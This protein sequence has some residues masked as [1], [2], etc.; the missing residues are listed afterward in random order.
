MT[1]Q[2]IGKLLAVLR[3]SFPPRADVDPDALVAAFEIGLRGIS[4][5]AATIAVEEW[6]QSGR[7]FPAPSEL[8][9]LV[10]SATPQLDA[11]LY[12]RYGHLRRAYQLG[13]ITTD[14]ERELAEIEHRLGIAKHGSRRGTPQ[15]QLVR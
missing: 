10:P 4:Y 8:R 6:I 2:E 1:K 3:V 13:T 9:A 12:G 5:Q 11:R 15:L 7:F 14:Q